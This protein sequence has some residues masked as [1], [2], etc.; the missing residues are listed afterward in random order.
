MSELFKADE[1]AEVAQL[2]Q[3]HGV[4]VTFEPGWQTR[5]GTKAD[6]PLYAQGGIEHWTASPNTKTSYLR[7]GDPGRGLGTLC[8]VQL[9]RDGTL[10]L[11]AAGYTN[12]AGTNNP[13]A[14]AKVR[15]ADMPMGSQWSPGADLPLFSGN[16]YFIGLEG[17]AGPGYP[18]TDAMHHSATVFWA[19]CAAVFG[20]SQACPPVAGHK[21]ITRRKAGDPSHDM[22]ERRRMVAA[23]LAEWA[24]PV[25]PVIPPAAPEWPLPAGWYFGPRSGPSESFSGYYGTGKTADAYRAALRAWQER[26]AARGW[27]IRPTGLYGAATARVAL[28]FQR[29]K[30]YLPASGRIRKR[31]FVGA[32][33]EPIT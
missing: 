2:C 3:A 21:E 6:R 30:G 12:H 4:T 19:A 11:I 9:L 5:K 14:V 26:M 22:A 25:D 1:F 16:R 33:T 18:Y 7:D 27:T 17:N 32:W 13:A 10:H 29:E 15:K 23:L 8:N 31:T 28:A 20:W 24:A